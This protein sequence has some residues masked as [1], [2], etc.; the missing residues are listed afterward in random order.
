M[1]TNHLSAWEQE[2]YILD[3]RT[4]QMLRHLSE[5]AECRAAVARL[6]DGLGVYRKAAVEWSAES[7]A[8]RPQQLL[9]ARKQPL[10]SLR[11]AMAAIIPLV[12]LL[13]ALL[14]FRASSPRP[15]QQAAQVRDDSRDDALLDQV[16]EQISAAVPSSM[17]SLTHL[18]STGDRA[19]AKGS[20]HLVQ[21]N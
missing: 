10:L 3:E 20:K 7:L 13:I 19:T 8:A 18:V 6:E 9:I 2:E 21:N 4:P 11:W 17:E 15:V 14:P 16:D 1:N 5:C 12:L